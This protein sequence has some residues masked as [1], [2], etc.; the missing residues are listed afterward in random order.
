HTRAGRWSGYIVIAILFAVACG[1]L[2]HWQFSRNSAR[3]AA[4]ALVEQNYAAPAVPL[5]DLV[6]GV[7]GFDDADEWRPVTVTGTY[8][9]AEQLFVRNR[10]LNGTVGYEVLVPLQL[11]DGRIFW[12]DRG[13]VPPS[14]G[15]APTG[16]PSPPEGTVT[17]TAHLKP[18]EPLRDRG[19]PEG[20]LANINLTLAADVSGQG[21]IT[22][23]YG[24]MMSE[25]PAASAS[26]TA[27]EAPD[28]DP[29][30]HL[31]YAIQWILFAIMG[32][33][34]IGYII[35]TERAAGEDSDDDDDDDEPRPRAKP[36]RKRDADMQYEDAVL[37]AA[38]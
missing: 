14:E 22:A 7:D 19:A 9:A 30:P 36:A 31:S 23:A 33:V 25:D 26:L 18:T 4:N 15:D 17:V 12:I 2:S 37:D 13:W 28:I 32:F 1:F 10:P 3:E 6:S 29:G 5:S 16:V 24:V 35:R 20:Q 34:F 8:L 27:L 21:T 38:G 11:D